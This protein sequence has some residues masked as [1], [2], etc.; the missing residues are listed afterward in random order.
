MT[1]Q[2]PSYGAIANETQT[3]V[4]RMMLGDDECKSLSCKVPADDSEKLSRPYSTRPPLTYPDED[5]HQ[6]RKCKQLTKQWRGSHLI[7]RELLILTT[8]PHF[9]K[10]ESRHLRRHQKG[11]SLAWNSSNEGGPANPRRP[12]WLQLKRLLLVHHPSLD[13]PRLSHVRLCCH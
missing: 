5:L 11:K 4:K 3:I 8:N 13:V 7:R 6:R 2:P 10:R 12:E 9:A 1:L